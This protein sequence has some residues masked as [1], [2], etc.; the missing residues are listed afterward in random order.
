ML[1]GASMGKFVDDLTFHAGD[2]L[3]FD[4]PTSDGTAQFTAI[5][6]GRA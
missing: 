3:F 6:Y 2:I 5:V 4:I 1:A